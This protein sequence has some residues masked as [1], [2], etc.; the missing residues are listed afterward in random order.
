MLVIAAALAI[1]D[2]LTAEG[3]ERSEALERLER[4]PSDR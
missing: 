4:F 1:G 3:F 2:G